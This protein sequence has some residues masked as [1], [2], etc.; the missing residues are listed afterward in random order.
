LGSKPIITVHAGSCGKEVI[1]GQESLVVTN[2]LENS[3]VL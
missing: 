2:M 1:A 3:F